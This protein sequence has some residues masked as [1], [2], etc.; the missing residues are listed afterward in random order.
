MSNIDEIKRIILSHKK[1]SF[2]TTN[3]K[4][5]RIRC[6][7]CG[8]SKS[9]PNDAHLYIQ[10]KAPFK[11]HCFK[12]ETSG[13]LN[14]KTLREMEIFDNELLTYIIN[15]KKE[16]N[17]NNNIYYY[18]Y[19]PSLKNNTTNLIGSS[20]LAYNYFLERFKVNITNNYII[21]KFKCILNPIQFIKDNNIYI[22]KKIKFDFSKAIGFISSDGSHV[23]F[24]NID[25][26]SQGQR[27]YNLNINNS[28]ESSK[29]YNIS[30]NVD[31]M[32]K[33]IK[34]VI[35]EGIFD[36][37]GVYLHFYKDKVPDDNIIFAAA[38]GKGYSAVINK[39]IKMGFLNMDIEIYS[40]GDVEPYFYKNMIKSSPYL[41][42]FK[43]TVYYNNLYDPI[44]KNGKDYGVPKEQIQLRKVLI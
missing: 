39:F 5:I 24:R 19:K 3:K 28:D 43:F 44:T 32:S 37:I 21:D 14:A 2:I 42:N 36:I 1:P 40:D 20:D 11:F 41:K 33:K 18:N 35:T 4:E 9:D 7:Y 38:C 22:D 13:T 10:M 17:L 26:N 16:N 27:Y 23:I 25:K 34:L 31:I 15:E 8:D 6:P 29:I 12:C 30:S